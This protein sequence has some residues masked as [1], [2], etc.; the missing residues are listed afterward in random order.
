MFAKRH[1]FALL[2]AL[3]ILSIGQ[4]ADQTWVPLSIEQV[5]VEIGQ[6][7]VNFA[8]RTHND[9]QDKINTRNYFEDTVNDGQLRS[10]PKRR[11][12]P[13]VGKDSCHEI[14]D[15]QGIINRTCGH[16]WGG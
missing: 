3:I 15:W 6:G 12:T 1:S 2:S 14:S 8:D 9:Q 16:T 4:I 10:I 13:V 5:F 7:A 11:N